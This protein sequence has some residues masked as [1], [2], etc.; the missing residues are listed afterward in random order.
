M[1]DKF[2]SINIDEITPTLYTTKIKQSI[3]IAISKSGTLFTPQ[4]IIKETDW[5]HKD[6][7]RAKFGDKFIMIKT[8]EGAA[9]EKS[10]KKH[11]LSVKQET[12]SKGIEVS[13]SK[14]IFVYIDNCNGH[15]LSKKWANK[16]GICVFYGV[17]STQPI[18]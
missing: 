10:F 7:I 2:L 3:S 12:I 15:S 11:L 6:E 17:C 8:A 18:D 9:T 1:K 14:P 13:R 16:R 4:V 5:E